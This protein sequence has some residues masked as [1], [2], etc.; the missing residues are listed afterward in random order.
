MAEIRMDVVDAK[1]IIEEFG[2]SIESSPK[3][4]PKDVQVNIA[5]TKRGN[6]NIV[7]AVDEALISAGYTINPPP[8]PPPPGP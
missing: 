8:P 3:P 4:E 7:K 6:T 1:E 2:Q 5:L